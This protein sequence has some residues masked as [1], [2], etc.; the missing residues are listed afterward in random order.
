[1]TKSWTDASQTPITTRKQRVQRL[2]VVLIIVLGMYLCSS[3]LSHVLSS[4][5][6]YVPRRARCLST[7]PAKRLQK[8]FRLPSGDEV[9]AIALGTAASAVWPCSC[10][11]C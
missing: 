10:A 4:A 5:A 11:A 1:M 9:P 8:T 3:T 2:A 6:A 7:T